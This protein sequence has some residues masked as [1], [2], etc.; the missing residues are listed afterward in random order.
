[1]AGGWAWRPQGW[2]EGGRPLATTG[3]VKGLPSTCP[4]PW[5]ARS[6]PQALC[7]EAPSGAGETELAS[8]GQT[9]R[10]GL[11]LTQLVPRNTP[12]MSTKEPSA[13]L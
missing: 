3:P 13:H 7:S 5:G 9:H 12:A 2:R 10:P 6:T 11:T 1:M 4:H 8:S